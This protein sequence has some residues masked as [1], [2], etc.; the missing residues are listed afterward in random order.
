M[1]I[2][3]SLPWLLCLHRDHLIFQM[4][5]VVS[6][7]WIQIRHLEQALEMTKVCSTGVAQ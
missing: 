3:A 7:Q 2:Y 1:S 5:S 6:E 4:S